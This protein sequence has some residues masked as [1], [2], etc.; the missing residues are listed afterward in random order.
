MNGSYFV[1]GGGYDN[2]NNL[3]LPGGMPTM[4]GGQQP[5][6]GMNKNHMIPGLNNVSFFIPQQPNNMNLFGSI[7]PQINNNRYGE[8]NSNNALNSNGQI[9][10]MRIQEKQQQQPPGLTSANSNTGSANNNAGNMTSGAM[11]SIGI[12]DSRGGNS[13]LQDNYK[14]M[15][16]MNKT[17]F[18]NP[19]GAYGGYQPAN[20]FPDISRMGITQFPG[21]IPFPMP[22]P[23][24]IPYLLQPYNPYGYTNPTMPGRFQ[25]AS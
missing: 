12:N 24:G 2:N 8:S 10:Q 15:M 20:S 14:R 5:Q 6:Q 17:P 19:F 9:D 22:P 16:D 1:G 3:M 4:P 23:G 13:L 21:Q 25:P 7:P 11:S 18:P